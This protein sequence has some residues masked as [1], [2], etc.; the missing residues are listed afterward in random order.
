MH[1]KSGRLALTSAFAAL[2]AVP[3]T[4]AS[5]LEKLKLTEDGNVTLGLGLTAQAW[6]QVTMRTDPDK[7]TGQALDQNIILRRAELML[8]FSVGEHFN[9][10]MNTTGR[11]PGGL[12]GLFNEGI[13]VNLLVAEMT[14]RVVPELQ[15]MGGLT[16][17]PVSRNALTLGGT[18]LTMDYMN[19][20]AKNLS[21]GM[22]MGSRFASTA[23]AGTVGNGN[24]VAAAYGQPS[25]ANITIFGEASAD[26]TTHLKYYLSIMRGT[27]SA[28]G[29]VVGNPALGKKDTPRLAGRI[30]V[31]LGDAES[32]YFNLG[33]YQG[34][35][36]T[37]A[38]GVSA[39][40]QPEAVHVGAIP[41]SAGVAAVGASAK[42]YLYV[43]AD[44]FAEK[45]VGEGSLTFDGAFSMLNVDSKTLD[46]VR[47]M[48]FSAQVAYL[49]NNV[50]PW[51]AYEQWIAKVDA[52]NVSAFRVGATY[53]F[54]G[55]KANAKLGYELMMGE[56]GVFGNGADQDK[57]H[58]V[59]LSGSMML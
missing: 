55:F 32:G 11:G 28:L 23:V 4:Q 18:L 47:G 37:I 52:G 35:K 53:Y 16:V 30:Q 9:F 54:E 59:V 39:D 45:A 33:S 12:G 24:D 5:A 49:I 48:G 44:I 31:N 42:D 27:T 19:T 36:D 40:F 34:A 8:D 21:L 25:E 26:P 51:L 29:A 2:L 3:A 6:G 43:S 41:A 13:S 14:F 38:I 46:A 15:F 56:K 57:L 58:T 50:Q 7:A 10:F 22:A 17:P 20:T 1:L